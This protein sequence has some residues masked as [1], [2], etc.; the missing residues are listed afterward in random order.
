[1]DPGPLP[2]KGA[3][4]PK[5]VLARNGEQGRRRWTT[6]DL[7]SVV[8]GSRSPSLFRSSPTAGAGHSRGRR[9]DRPARRTAGTA[10]RQLPRSAACSIPSPTSSSWQSAFGVVA[11]SGRL[12]SYEIV[13][14]SCCATSWPRSRSWRRS[15]P[16]GPRAIPARRGRQ[17]GDGGTGA[18]PGRVPHR[19]AAA[20][21][22]GVGHDRGLADLRDLGL[23][24]GRARGRATGGRSGADERGDQAH[25]PGLGAG[26]GLPGR[27]AGR[28]RHVVDRRGQRARRRVRCSPCSSRPPPAPGP[29]W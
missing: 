28:S 24:P 6:A 8:R 7:L 19:L 12:A 10:V 15:T 18:H 29:T 5:L 1:M 16:T 25:R 22:D 17:G 23:L 27:R 20:P 13:G 9:R 14:V 3:R 21:A 2:A 26:H 11:L 4:C